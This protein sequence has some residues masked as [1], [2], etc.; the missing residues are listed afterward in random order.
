MADG[1]RLARSLDVLRDEI[2]AVAPGTTVWDLGDPDHQQRNSDHNPNAAG[3]VCAI[4]VLGD[5]GLDLAAFA[6]HVRTS[7]HVAAKY[8]IHDRRI[9]SRSRGWRWR[10]YRGSNPHTSHVHVSVGRGPDGQSTG[11]YDDTSSWGLAATV[12]GDVIRLKIGDEGERVKGL[13]AL[14]RYAGFEDE[15]GEVDGVYGPMTAAGVLAARRSVGSGVDSGDTVSGWAYAQIQLAL[16]R[17]EGG[18]ERGPEGP[19]GPAGERGPAGPAGEPGPQG[20]PGPTPTHV[21]IT[22]EVTEVQ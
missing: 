7:G 1:W 8:A 13:Q 18:G 10:R 16:T 17:A 6:E 21:Q 4:D 22:G 19:R 20:P 2:L 11:P 3:V 14:L 12:G 15:V 5:G 9:A